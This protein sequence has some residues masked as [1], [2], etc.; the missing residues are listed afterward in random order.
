MEHT[1]Q[2]DVGKTKTKSQKKSKGLE[3]GG[4]KERN[5]C[6]QRCMS[7][8]PALSTCVGGLGVGNESRVRDLGYLVLLGL[9][10]VHTQEETMQDHT[11][12]LGL[13]PLRPMLPGH[14][15]AH[16]GHPGRPPPW[17]GLP[18]LWAH[19]SHCEGSARTREGCSVALANSDQGHP[20]MGP[21][22]A[23]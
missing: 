9:R 7:T 2:N 16:I 23:R 1:I 19:T 17:T 20:P 21:P 13:R 14:G 5:T 18:G 12:R 8:G 6:G 11:H 15:L 4:Q 22:M 3:E 10:C